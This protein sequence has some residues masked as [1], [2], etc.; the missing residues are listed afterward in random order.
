MLFRTASP[1]PSSFSGR[2][3]YYAGRSKQDLLLKQKNQMNNF[4]FPFSNAN[5]KQDTN[6]TDSSHEG[7]LEE[8]KRYSCLEKREKDDRNNRGQTVL[9]G[10]STQI[11]APSRYHADAHIP[12]L[13]CAGISR[14]G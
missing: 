3:H 9:G 1:P 5:D 14:A 6:T 13:P 2:M 11:G 7:A 10:Q 4:S 8:K 12:H